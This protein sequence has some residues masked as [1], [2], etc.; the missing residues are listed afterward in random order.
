MRDIMAAAHRAILE[1][2]AWSNVLLGFDFDGTLA[3]IVDRPAQASL[4]D[5]TRALLG[6][7]C[8]LYPAVVISGRAQADVF[9]K[10]RGTGVREVIGNHGVQRWNTAPPQDRR[11]ERWR[12]LLEDV[13]R[14]HKG[15]TVEDKGFS[16]AVHYR[17]SREKRKARAVILRA[18]DTLTGARV[19]CGKQVINVRPADAVHKGIALERARARLG[20]DTAI[21]VGDDE[22]DEDVFALDRPGRLLTIR[23]GPSRASAAAYCVRDQL[24]VDRLLRA[25]I[26]FRRGVGRERQAVG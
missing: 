10:V 14:T 22:T 9:R 16:I 21:Y 26:S 25:L 2:F 11:V 8:G 4:R 17:S 24:A 12:A 15:V 5:A 23:V 20:C 3:P 13:V 7:L 1:E 6:V 18:A 19:T